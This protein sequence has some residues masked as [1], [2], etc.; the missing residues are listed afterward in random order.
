[1]RLEKD[2]L[3]AKVENLE[4][5]LKQLHDEQNNEE[6][7]EKGLSK[8]EKSSIAAAPS[9]KVGANSAIGQN[10]SQPNGI[11]KMT[12]KPTPIPK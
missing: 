4:I 9:Q 5:S 7:L 12:K 2:R 1:M 3:I 6:S 10:A 8:Y 11:L